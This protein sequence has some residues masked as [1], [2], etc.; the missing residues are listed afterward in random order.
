MA[1][2]TPLATYG[3]RGFLSLAFKNAAVS[4]RSKFSLA[5]TLNLEQCG[6]GLRFWVVPLGVEHLVDVLDWH[7]SHDHAARLGS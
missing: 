2:E 6:P 5:L 7:L 1:I 4:H 3:D